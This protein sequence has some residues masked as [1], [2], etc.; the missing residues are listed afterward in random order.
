VLV[1]PVLLPLDE[2]SEEE[3][4]RCWFD[5]EDYKAIHT[6][7]LGALKKSFHKHKKRRLH[8]QQQHQQHQQSSYQEPERDKDKDKYQDNDNDNDKYQDKYQDNAFFRWTPPRGL[9]RWAL[10]ERSASLERRLLALEAVMEA[11]RHTGYCGEEA[12]HAIMEV[13]R[14]QAVVA[15]ERARAMALRDERAAWGRA[16]GSAAAL[17]LSSSS[18][19]SSLSLSSSRFE[20][21]PPKRRIVRLV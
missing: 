1:R 2:Y 11:Q 19:S 6:E 16:L 15:S 8:Q 12:E 13:Y 18:S 21:E 9:E 14:K 17:S 4:R 7:A 10:P 5:R 3:H 20:F